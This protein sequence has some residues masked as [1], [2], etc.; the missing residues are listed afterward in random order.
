MKRLALL[1]LF[2]TALCL[3]LHA[4]TDPV[5]M[6]VNGKD[7]TR[8]EF[9]Y[10]YNK[11]NS[12]GVIDKKSV[13]E[14]VP[15]FIDFKLKVAAAE[16][17]RY[18]TVT[19]I[20]KDLRSYKEQMV[21]PT[22]IDK[23]F[24]ER[25]ARNTYDNTAARFEGADLLTASH[26]LVR[27]G[28][29]ATTDEQAKAKTRIDSIYT[30]LQGGADFAELARKC[31]EDPG[32]AARGG[33][34]GQFGKGMMIP[35]FEKAAYA[36]KKG[37][38]SAPFKSTVGWHI[39][40]LEDRHPFESY[41]FHHESILKFLESRGV[42]EA[43]ANYH[44]DSIAKA[45]NVERDVVISELFEDLKAKDEET[46][47]LSQEYYDGT[48]MY[49]ICKNQIW[50]VA[51]KDEEGMLK[52]YNKNKKNY[53]WDEPRFKGIVIS[54]KEKSIVDNAAKLLKKTKDDTQWGKM[55][56][57]A[58]NTDS[59]K[60]VRIEHGI[61]KK[62]DSPNVDKLEFGQPTELKP[63]RDY[64]YVGTYGRVL[65]KPESYKDV[66]GQLTVDYQ[67]AVEKEWVAELRKKYSFTVNEAVLKTVNNH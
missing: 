36:L 11:N 61:Y 42:N 34:L 19:A 12:D 45:R 37:E 57:E 33:S 6:T 59:V 49:E 32:S 51:A 7:I 22:I 4:Q 44:I 5:I 46:R 65:K 35:D 60:N 29:N 10:S 62:G 54:A 25:E 43:S 2:I 8:S 38:T 21:L 58:Y 16:D 63:F 64:P 13:D 24:I 39:V 50:D 1:H 27:M 31:S 26:I 28:P 41:E 20:Q 30:A 66:I 3:S 55:M 18:D 17:A 15:L 48:M 52:Y 56:V 67:S 40:K 9:E 14:Y 53:Q 47:F 23:D